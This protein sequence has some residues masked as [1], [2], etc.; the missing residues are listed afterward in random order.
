MKLGWSVNFNMKVKDLIE[1][2]SKEAQEFKQ[3]TP[4]DFKIQR[5]EPPECN[6]VIDHTKSYYPPIKGKRGKVRR[7]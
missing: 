3:L 6:M 5:A 4:Q 1:I 2:L 7:W